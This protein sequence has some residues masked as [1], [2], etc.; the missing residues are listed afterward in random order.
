MHTKGFVWL[1]GHKTMLSAINI[2]IIV[3]LFINLF[4]GLVQLKNYCSD[5]NDE[6]RSLVVKLL[7]DVELLDRSVSEGR[8]FSRELHQ[9]IHEFKE[10][11]KGIDG[12][13]VVEDKLYPREDDDA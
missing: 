10:L 2:V 11:V 4:F 7:S 13:D 1:R 12:N 5:C 8:D 9:A 6:V 3:D